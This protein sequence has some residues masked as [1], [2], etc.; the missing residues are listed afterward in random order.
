MPLKKHI[1]M[2]QKARGRSFSS[3]HAQS[4]MKMN[5]YLWSVTLKELAGT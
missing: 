4:Q 1:P 3:L 5:E 2:I